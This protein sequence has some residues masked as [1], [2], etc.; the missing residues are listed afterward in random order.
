MSAFDIKCRHQQKH[1]L[2]RSVMYTY[3]KAYNKFS[4]NQEIKSTHRCQ[5]QLS[6]FIN[7]SSSNIIGKLWYYVSENHDKGLQVC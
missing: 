7:T 3:F 1:S 2:K 5:R 4:Y 6:S